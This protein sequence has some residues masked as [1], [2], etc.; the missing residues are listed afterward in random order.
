MLATD[1][2]LVTVNRGNAARGGEPDI[3][4]PRHGETAATSFSTS[5]VS[6]I[7]KRTGSS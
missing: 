6:W 4:I 7:A 2:A 3:F 5:R 1:H